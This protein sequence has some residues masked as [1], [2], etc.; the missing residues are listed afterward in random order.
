MYQFHS[1]LEAYYS[2]YDNSQNIEE[3]YD[4]VSDYLLDNFEFDS[5]EHLDETISLLDYDTIETIINE[6]KGLGG[7]VSFSRGS[8][9]G[10]E[11][12]GEKRRESGEKLRSKTASGEVPENQLDRLFNKSAGMSLTPKDKAKNKLRKLEDREDDSPETKRRIGRL[13]DVLKKKS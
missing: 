12:P 3:T 9:H 4:I 7:G 5:Q 1:L 10:V 2:I 13:R 11:S 6:V 8:Y